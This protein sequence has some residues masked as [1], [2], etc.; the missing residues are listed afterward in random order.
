[1]SNRLNTTNS[2]ERALAVMEHI[3]RAPGLSNAEISRALAIPKSTCSWILARLE[4]KGYLA[5]DA[6]GRYRIGLT[7]VALAYGAL[8][9]LGLRSIAEPALYQLAEATRL[10]A[11]IG[12]LERGRVLLVDRVESREFMNDVVRL[13]ALGGRK[14]RYAIRRREQ[15]DIGRE[16]PAHTNALG[17]I[18]LAWL[19]R[20]QVSAIVEQ[21]GLR[22]AT[23]KTITSANRLFEELKRV[24]EL[25]YATSFEEQYAGICAVGAPVFDASG[26]VTAAVS[27]TGGPTAANWREPADLVR[28]VRA[29]ALIISNRGRLRGVPDRGSRR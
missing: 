21:H 4:R 8:R 1:M 18:L 28:Q 13:A 29:A 25:G 15:R 10:S 23:P 16:L 3:E 24:R 7:T 14:I 9:D 20:E 27:V 2:L 17:K 5:R 22:R 26:S 6:A 12:V 11:S 19:D